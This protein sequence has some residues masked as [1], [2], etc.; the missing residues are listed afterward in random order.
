MLLAA[1]ISAAGAAAQDKPKQGAGEQAFVPKV[2]RAVRVDEP[3]VID[4]K[5]TENAWQRDGTAAF[6]QSDPKDGEPATE[7]TDV[8]VAYDDKNLYVAAYLYDSDPPNIKCRLGRRDA[9]VDSDWFYFAVDPYGDKR[10]GYVFGINPTCSVFDSVLSNDVNE[11]DSW[12]GVWDGIGALGDK[13]WT[14]EM[15]IPFNQIRFPKKDEY[16]WGVNFKRVVKRKNEISA[17]SWVPKSEPAFV[18]KFARLEG[19]SGISPGRH[20]EFNPYLV[21]RAQYRPEE[22]G[23]PFETGS[24]YAGDIGFDLKAGLRSN[25]T[26]DTT[27][28]PDFGQVEVDPAVVNLSAYETYYQEKRPF[29]IEGASI[30]DGFGQGGIYIN[31]NINWPSPN[32]F[33]SR[34]IGRAP[35]GSVSSDGFAFVPDRTTIL[36]A[37]KITGKFGGNWNLGFISALTAGERAEIDQAGVRLREEVEPRSYYGVF[38]AQKD[39]QEGRS[40]I[41]VIATAIVRDL[42]SASLSEILNRNAFSLAVD[43][44][45][46]LDAK[47]NWVFGG[48]AGGTRVEGSVEDILR[49]QRSSLHYFQRPD[50]GHVE[51]GTSATSMSGWGGRFTLAKQQGNVLVMAAAGALSPGFDPNDLGFQS[52]SSDIIN[53]QF[54]TGRQWTKPGKTFIYALAAGGVFRN[55]SFAGDK[56]WDGVL[57][58][59]QGQFTNFW[60]FESML[61]YNPD[62]VSTTLTRG[63]PKAIIPSGHQVDLSISTDSR[64]SIV[65]EAGGTVYRRPKTGT[66]WS[67]RISLR[68]KPAP[69]LSLSAGPIVGIE[70]ND[71]QWVRRVGDSEMAATYGNR[72]VFGRLDQKTIGSEIRLDW[73][74][75]PRLTL[76]AY[77][78]PFLSVGTYDRFKELTRPKS[79]NYNVYG[80]NGSTIDYA[81][82]LYTID[83]DGD[84]PAAA[85]TFDNP[86]FNFKSLRGTVVLRWEYLPGSLLYL[87]WTQNRANYA[88]PGE[89]RLGRDLSDL[90]TAAGDNIFL[91]KVS[92][93]WNM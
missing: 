22:A 78:Q 71:I 8:W 5:L 48:W 7:K 47:R 93:R 80:E 42:D 49:L 88:H 13:G 44:W 68:W 77:L 37:A 75:T 28:N 10:T 81:D 18:S 53:L 34:R 87:V 63:G 9:Q 4:G 58:L 56:T 24:R 54:I 35:Q 31:A 90:F 86:D 67:G 79:F 38:R 46:F 23:N 59:L 36:G 27:V 39:I 82:E 11:D 17:F 25:L 55:Y 60:R 89:L 57:A 91:L 14:V 61:A 15:R 85:F 40:G 33:Y 83:P 3:I 19:I 6:T 43:G 30:F 21:G 72:Y 69:N 66:E 1:S 41:G 2:I 50:A 32:F 29:F 20:I 52:G 74:F 16:V 45:K 65:V 62:T 73:T 76:Q 12:D 84:G 92:Y 51:V 26:L 70:T 64:K